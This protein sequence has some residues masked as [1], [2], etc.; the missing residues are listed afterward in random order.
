MNI[1]TIEDAVYSIIEKYF[2]V[3]NINKNLKWEKGYYDLIWNLESFF[4]VEFESPWPATAKEMVEA[5][6]QERKN[7]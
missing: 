4:E 5:I 6:K 1:Q 7:T 3:V 2:G